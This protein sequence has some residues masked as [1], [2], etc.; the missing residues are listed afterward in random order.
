MGFI[1]VDSLSR[2]FTSLSKSV[3]F[4]LFAVKLPLSSAT[5]PRPRVVDILAF[6][7][8][9]IN[10]KEQGLQLWETIQFKIHLLPHMGLIS[11]S[12][13]GEG[14]GPSGQ[15]PW[16]LPKVWPPPMRAT[17]VGGLDVKEWVARK[18][19]VYVQVKNLKCQFYR[20][21][22]NKETMINY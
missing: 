14:P 17:L 9:E 5:L 11:R 22:L 20:G 10:R 2:P 4:T 19:I 7:G 12:S 3:A 8:H 18:M 21:F 1:L 13:R 6:P 16:V 15:A